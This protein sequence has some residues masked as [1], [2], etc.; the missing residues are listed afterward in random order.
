MPVDHK[1]AGDV[2]FILASGRKVSDTLIAS[3]QAELWG[4]VAWCT[5]GTNYA[6][7]YDGLTA[8]GANP[9][10]VEVQPTA[11]QGTDVVMFP[12]PVVALNGLYLSLGGNMAAIV[13]YKQ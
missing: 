4:I 1:L 10:I 13:Y 7:V 8:A 9:R 2:I 12:H 5:S 3:G 11:G 6:R